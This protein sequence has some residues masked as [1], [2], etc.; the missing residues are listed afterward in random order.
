MN[1]LVTGANGQ[2]GK[3]IF[4]VRAND[5]LP[6]KGNNW[7]FAG[8]EDLDIGVKDLVFDYVNKNEIDV[9][10][11]CAA[12]TDVEKAESHYNDAFSANAFGPIYMAEA[13]KPRHGVLI[14]IST[15]Y[16]YA[17]YD[18]W[19][20]SPFNEDD[21]AS[22]K[23]KMPLNMYGISKLS[24]EVGIM[25]N[26]GNYLIIRTS[27]LYS[28]YGK[29]FLK[30]VRNKCLNAKINENFEFVCDQIGSPTSAHN[31]AA[32]IYNFVNGLDKDYC[33]YSPFYSDIINYSDEG[34][35]SWYDFAREI[36]DCLEKPT[37]IM[38]CFSDEYKTAAKRPAYS[39]MSK[40]KINRC[41][42]YLPYVNTEHWKRGVR[43]V[44]K[45]LEVLEKK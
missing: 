34:A 20:G 42:R 23:L 11:N 44:M 16:V 26:G 31:L 22:M 39:V 3:C 13:L 18:G 5:V 28:I 21:Y 32:F 1:I 38:P 8:H 24:G 15:D 19:D 7:F 40:R 4:D 37:I 6:Q 33:E 17:P 45:R 35:C 27:W 41:D 12:Y 29:N 36:N 14:H 2:L 43:N 10:I 30:T 9:I 25:R